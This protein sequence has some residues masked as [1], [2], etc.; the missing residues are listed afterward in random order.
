MD[1][2]S[3]PE[4]IFM[5]WP[6]NYTCVD[7]PAPVLQ[8]QYEGLPPDFKCR[9]S[10]TLLTL[11][12]KSSLTIKPCRYATIHFN[13][14]VK[15]SL[16]AITMIY[17]SDFLYRLGITCVINQIPT[18]DSFLNVTIFNHKSVPI[19]LE[20]KTLQFTCHTVLAKYP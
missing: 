18:N 9:T 1:D 16:P 20:K 4:P 2:I 6:E 15:T 14:L 17:G 13:V 8:I 19:T 3:I 12:N 10:T 11:T 7:S 5:K